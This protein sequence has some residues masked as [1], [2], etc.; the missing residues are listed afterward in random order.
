[1]YR[2]YVDDR[3]LFDPLSTEFL[4][5]EPKMEQERNKTGSLEFK[6]PITNPSYSHLSKLKSIVS[7]YF[8]NSLLDVFRVLN[9]ESDFKNT[10][11]VY[12]EGVMAFLLDS[13]CD[14]R[15][16][17]NETIESFVSY[18][19]GFHNENANSSKW[20]SKGQ[21][22]T[23]NTEEH[24]FTTSYG[25]T[26]DELNKNIV[27][28]FGGAF[29]V[30]KTDSGYLLNYT[31]DY[32]KVNSQVLEFSKNIIDLNKAES[33]T[34][35]ATRIVP[36]GASIDDSEER[37]TI[38]E[39]NDNKIYVED[40]SAINEFG[41]IT[42]VLDLS[43]ETDPNVL[44]KKAQKELSDKKKTK[45]T[46][47]LNAV[48]L[49]LVSSDFEKIRVNENIRVK[50]EPNNIDEYFLVSKT[51]TDFL[52][53]E[54]NKVTL[55][56]TR[57]SLKQSILST[58]KENINYLFNKTTAQTQR[59]NEVLSITDDCF[60]EISKTAE[61][62]RSTVAENYLSKGTLETI[63]KDF[64]TSI[65]QKSDEIRMDFLSVTDSISD[66]I[67]TSHEL[68]EEYIRFKG[69]LIEL[70]RLGNAF[71]AE[72]S[73][74]E[75]AFFEDGEKIAFISNQKLYILSAEILNKL[76]LGDFVFEIRENGNLS[77][78]YQS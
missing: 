23:K 11:T 27:E 73:N 44:L 40:Q 5:I 49:N 32:T 64:E 1:M 13:V 3:L 7:V 20:I 26:L 76:T 60:S 52:N 72:L 9:I 4:V 51:Q 38:K 62:I 31:D 33:G 10:M 71:S 75:L 45:T 41:V 36:L 50:S 14:F 47:E 56:K 6:V 63:Y 54:N 15:V 58:Q 69:A 46:I 8:N 77:I 61:E 21:I 65:T 28:N 18:L 68:L 25:T 34:E 35:I 57:V 66:E 22:Q 30:S 74:E 48:D 17:E 67:S 42:K 19:L 24:R 70:G 59:L 55:G 2:F 39:I 43:E 53:P 29:Y 37:I 78:K 12:C 16:Y